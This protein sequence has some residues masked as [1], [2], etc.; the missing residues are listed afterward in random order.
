MGLRTQRGKDVL[1]QW[2]LTASERVVG[3]L[4]ASG[5]AELYRLASNARQRIMGT[6]SEWKPFDAILLEA[7]IDR[8]DRQH[9]TALMLALMPRVLKHEKDAREK[10]VR[11]ARARL[12]KAG[13]AVRWGHSGKF[14]VSDES[15][16]S[17]NESAERLASALDR[18]AKK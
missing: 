3:R 10:A 16:T 2:L 1:P 9:A 11:E 8:S 4:P 7:G 15:C 18:L 13:V 14:G 6:P 5:H 17:I 12:A